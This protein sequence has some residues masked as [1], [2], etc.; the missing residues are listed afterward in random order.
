MRSHKGICILKLL[1]FTA[2]GN[3]YETIFIQE[4]RYKCFCCERSLY[5]HLALDEISVWPSRFC[6]GYI[7]VMQSEVCGGRAEDNLRKKT[8]EYLLMLCYFPSCTEIF[9]GAC[10][11]K[12]SSHH[13]VWPLVFLKKC[14][15]WWLSFASVSFSWLPVQ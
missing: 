8:T 2:L 9:H 5:K 6:A 3:E 14:V 13:L 10:W 1:P 12:C 11:T 15:F 4:W 7:T